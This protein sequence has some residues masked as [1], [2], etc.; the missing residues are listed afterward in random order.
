MERNKCV[1]ILYE[2]YNVCKV[3]MCLPE[4]KERQLIFQF[5]KPSDMAVRMSV[6]DT[7]VVAFWPKLGNVKGAHLIV[8]DFHTKQTDLIRVVMTHTPCFLPDGRLLLAKGREISMHRIEDGTLSKALWIC[9][10]LRD[11]QSICV[12]EDGHIYASTLNNQ[13]VI[14]VISLQGLFYSL[15]L[16]LYPI[17]N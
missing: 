8:Y 11:M 4:L 15:R 12:D 17:R 1:Y 13:R 10:G 5:H 3:A 9:P 2:E 7:H 14:Y 16:S 6:S